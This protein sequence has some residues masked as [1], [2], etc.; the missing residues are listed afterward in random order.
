MVFADT[1]AAGVSMASVA[2]I[3][4]SMNSVTPMTVMETV[5]ASMVS[6][7]AS[8]ESKVHPAKNLSVQADVVMET[9]SKASAIAL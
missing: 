1:V 2:K 8:L 9:A 7:S 6:A 5:F 3:A 4:K